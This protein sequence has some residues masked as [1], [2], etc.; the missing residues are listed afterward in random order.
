MD[1]GFSPDEQALW[2][3]T[4]KV[5]LEQLRPDFLRRRDEAFEAGRF[6][7]E[8]KVLGEVGLLGISL[9]E[10]W[11]GGGRSNLE[12]MLAIE[13]I[14]WGCPATGELALMAISG[15]PT[16]VAKWGT[17]DQ[18][19]RYI[20]GIV[21]GETSASISLTEPQAGTDL[22]ALRTNAVVRGDECILNGQKI[23]CSNAWM[24]DW[25]LVFC[26]FGPGSAGIG[27]VI[28]D[29]DTPGFT[30]GPS[31]RHMS[32]KPWSELFFDDAV[33]PAENVLFD[34][35]GF[36]RLL[37]SYSL[38]RCA[39]GAYVLGIAQLALDLSV[40]YVEERTQFGRPIS[41]FQFVQ[42]HLADMFLAIEQAR[43]LVHKAVSVSEAGVA[44]RM[45]SSA[46]KV[47][48]T[49]AAAFATDKAM[50]LHG[51]SGMSLDLPFEWLYRL[52]RPYTVAGGTSDIHRSMIAGE[53]VGRRFSHR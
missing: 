11:G 25:F 17:D 45:L 47:A 39:A 52:V 40:Q 30:V 21:T 19:R 42:A 43:L 41:D 4:T 10:E 32:G 15:P 38:E 3:L 5:A 31:H 33:I 36:S 49:E 14:S 29:R 35:N 16:F 46:A 6:E 18:K 8:R 44:Q 48:A 22:G 23:F 53:L 37:A 24:S 27:A 50:Q 12:A 20:P 2:D 1:F 9:P 13:R 51:G 34:G 28:V 7:R 26:R